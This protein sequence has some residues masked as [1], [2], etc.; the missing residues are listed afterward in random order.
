ME[1]AFQTK[2]DLCGEV[3]D[4]LS[5]WNMQRKRAAVE[6]YWPG[7]INGASEIC[8]A[9]DGASQ[10]V[11]NEIIQQWREIKAEQDKKNTEHGHLFNPFALIPIG[12]T[13]H[14]QLLGELL[15][16]RGKHGQGRLLLHAFLE[17]LG[18][19]NPEGGEWLISIEGGKVD[20]CLWRLSPPSVIIIENKSNW[21]GDMENQLYRY[22]YQ[23]IYRSYPD[24]V[25]SLEETKRSF[26]IIYLPP[27]AGKTPSPNSLQRSNKLDSL[28]LPMDLYEVG[29]TVKVLTFRDDIADWLDACVQRIPKT[30]TRLKAYLQFYKELWR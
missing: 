2:L 22:W 21:A 8:A 27:M 29:V 13:T 30:N 5:A 12:E 24:L 7:V 3:I 26:Q 19:P 6:R 17:R 10:R 14:S 16:P 9:K 1:I 28:G 23:N 20:I 11:L 4:N 15:N 18:V 25:Y